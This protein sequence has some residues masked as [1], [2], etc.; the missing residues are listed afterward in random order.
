MHIE[1]IKEALR[2]PKSR[3]QELIIFDNFNGVHFTSN[4]MAHV[5]SNLDYR[6]Y[7]Y[8]QHTQW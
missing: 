4:I 1:N 5:L 6:N 3:Y 8:K 2:F 7:E